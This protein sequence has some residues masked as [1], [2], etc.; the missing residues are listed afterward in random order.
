MTKTKRKFLS[1]FGI[2]LCSARWLLMPATQLSSDGTI[3]KD[4]EDISKNCHIYLICE[5][6]AISFDKSSFLYED[7]K[8]CGRIIYKID[9]IENHESFS[10]EFPLLDEAV[11][12][13][14]SKYPHREIQTFDK[15]G[16]C[17]RFL[18]ASAI[19]V[20]HSPHTT[21]HIFRKL[22]VLYVGQAFGNGSRTARDRLKNHGTLQKILADASYTS[23]DSEIFVLTVEYEPYRLIASFDG[24][25][26]KAVNDNRDSARFV[27]ILENPLRVR[28]QISIAEAALIRYFQPHYN[29][30]YK[31]KFPSTDLKILGKCY[32]YDFS[33][34]FVEIN[35]DELGLSLHSDTA[36]PKMHHI[37]N[38]DLVDQES[39][40]SFF[41][42]P[43]DNG[44][45]IRFMPSIGSTDNQGD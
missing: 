20:G 5:R 18:P 6:P 12:L 11:E 43:G 8:I 17:V 25:S 32:E 42:F 14:L 45:Q 34:L 44:Q 16:E 9:G 41:H 39:R 3:S 29:Q 37:V 26:K 13:R 2:N 15:D 1:E 23:P 4:D 31:K 24:I 38:I 10:V 36:P 30:I 27:S 21:N 28:E 7:G 35:T 33:A 19:S 40:A 22:K